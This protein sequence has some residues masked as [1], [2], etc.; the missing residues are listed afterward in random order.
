MEER[1]VLNICF[2]QG[3]NNANVTLDGNAVA[4]KSSVGSDYR[5]KYIYEITKSGTVTITANSN[6]Y[7]GYFEVVF[8][9]SFDTYIEENTTITFGNSSNINSIAGVSN[10]AVLSGNGNN[11]QFS[12][13][14]I[15]LRV[16]TGA[17]VTVY[18]YGGSTG[19]NKGDYTAY[20][21]TAN[22]STSE[23]QSG[24]YSVTANA[25]GEVVITSAN[26]NNYLMSITIEYPTE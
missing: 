2:Y 23:T 22:G 6:G 7:I 4:L 16:K 13:G 1:C 14:S 3:T 8:G 10:Y 19:T 24:D 21:V 17:V 5:K 12:D 25:D 15:I 18:G 11:S 26:A 20:T 9:A